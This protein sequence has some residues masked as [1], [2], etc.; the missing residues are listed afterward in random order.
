MFKL[1]NR[2]SHDVH[3]YTQNDT[4]AIRTSAHQSKMQQHPM[5]KVKAQHTQYRNEVHILKATFKP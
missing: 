1:R 2:L 3:E 5:L 4:V